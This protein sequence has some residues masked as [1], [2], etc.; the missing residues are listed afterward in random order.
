MEIARKEPSSVKGVLYLCLLGIAVILSL[1][2]GNILTAN[3]G[4]FPDFTVFGKTFPLWLIILVPSVIA[5]IYVFA[6]IIAS[7]NDLFKGKKNRWAFIIVLII[8]IIYMGCLI[9]LKDLTHLYANGF[10]N[11]QNTPTLNEKIW[12]LLTFYLSTLMI[13][14]FF[15]LFKP[16]KGYRKFLT[17]LLGSMILFTISACIYSVIQEQAAYLDFFKYGFIFKDGTHTARSFF[18]IGNV[19]GHLCYIAIVSILVLSVLYKKWIFVFSILFV[20]FIFVS[21][22]RAATLST[23][24]LYF[25]YFIYSY[26]SSFKKHKVLCSIITV[27]LVGGVTYLLLDTYIFKMI[28]IKDGESMIYLIDAL[29]LFKKVLINERLEIIKI[30]LQNANWLDLIVGTGYGLGFI[31]PRT[32]GYYY[33]MHDT[34]FE[35]LVHGGV[36][37]LAFIICIYALML[38]KAVKM[39]KYNK[40]ILGYFIALSLSQAIYGFFESMPM[41]FGDFFGGC[42]GMFFVLIIN[43]EY[44]KA[45]GRKYLIERFG[46][47]KF[48]CELEL[49][50][51][52]YDFEKGKFPELNNMLTQLQECILEKMK[53]DKTKHLNVVVLLGSKEKVFLNGY[54]S[55]PSNYEKEYKAIYYK[56]NDTYYIF[57][58]ELL[59]GKK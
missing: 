34:I 39:Y 53:K 36:P 47:K 57:Y 32:Y 45:L 6:I 1:F 3:I 51:S 27:I 43:L 9:F 20:P 52:M 54:M 42:F 55:D 22:C 11:E 28:R 40:K 12:S 21:R 48:E 19:F 16:V 15:Y 35:Y 50:Y 59:N 44:D 30:V 5:L 13:Y 23:V 31:F 46:T 29:N 8:L 17:I 10:P 56:A 58:S 26:L 18:V 2:Y 14:S 49:H 38:Y 4:N 33:Y 24:A 7:H 25:F 41:L 37:Y